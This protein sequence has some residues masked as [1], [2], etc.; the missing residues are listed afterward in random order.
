MQTQE[1]INFPEI[2][3]NIIYFNYKLTEKM[4]HSFTN[5]LIGA[6][7][8]NRFS[9]S[10]VELKPASGIFDVLIQIQMRFEC[11]LIM[12]V[13]FKL[14]MGRILYCS[15]MGEPLH[16]QSKSIIIRRSLSSVFTVHLELVDASYNMNAILCSRVTNPSYLNYFSINLWNYSTSTS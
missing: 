1:T 9:L 16:Y 7:S 12:C 14:F 4:N 10:P 13:K 6:L 8:P 5:Y 2:L 15:V 3:E 11:L